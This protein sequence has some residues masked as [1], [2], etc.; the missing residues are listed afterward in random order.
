MQHT[1]TF[2][3][4]HAAGSEA[5]AD[6]LSAAAELAS[7]PGVK[8]FQIRRQVSPKCTHT[9]GIS[10]NIDSEEALQSYCDH[11]LHAEFVENRWIPEVEDFQEAD[12][13]SL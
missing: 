5:E 8:D 1:V 6:F 9:F 7:I 12:F 4:K 3:L 2:R 11:P 13:I 10:M